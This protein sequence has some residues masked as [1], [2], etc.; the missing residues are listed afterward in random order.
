MRRKISIIVLLFIWL[1]VSAVATGC[2]A[3]AE[4]SEELAFFEQDVPGLINNI[5]WAFNNADFTFLFFSD[6]H[7][8]WRNLDKMIDIANATEVGAVI[9]AGDTVLKYLH[10]PDTDFSWYP[11]MVERIN[12]AFLPA[13]GNHDVWDSAYW[14]KAE[15][16]QSYNMIIFPAINGLSN[17]SQP[18]QAGEQGLCYYY[19]DNQ[20]IRIIVLN[21]MAGD[22]SVEF[23][24]SAQSEWLEATLDDALKY[25]KQVIC[26]THAP[27]R[28][29][30]A[31]RDPLLNWNSV[32]DYR[33]TD[34][35]D[36][37]HTHMDAVQIVQ[38]YIDDG[39]TFICW[40]SGH[41]HV[42]EV[43]EA[44]GYE[45]Q[46][47]FGIAS[48]RY[49]FHDDGEITDDKENPQFY[50]FDLIGVDTKTGLLRRVRLGWNVDKSMRTRNTMCYDYFNGYIVSD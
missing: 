15:S 39:G 46:I 50:C 22:D 14:Q 37:I 31:L 41:T 16:I 30:I 9:N 48:A 21:A 1:L 19:Y 33:V 32:D 3:T 6:L 11:S 10:D 4:Q 5:D 29:D 45:G 8:G 42:D 12:A 7:N 44:E 18:S 2:I 40:L 49:S 26:V 27:F 36:N 47:M 13:V 20:R 35:Y 34:D 38:N 43:I 17:V 28:K 24:D 25:K 23:W